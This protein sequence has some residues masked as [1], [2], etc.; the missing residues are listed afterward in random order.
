MM[1]TLQA[2]VLVV[3]IAAVKASPFLPFLQ[4]GLLHWMH[5]SE[6]LLSNLMLDPTVVL[7]SA[8]AADVPVFD[9]SGDVVNSLSAI[10][11]QL[12]EGPKSSVLSFLDKHPEW[13]QSTADFTSDLVQAKVQTPLA[14]KGNEIVQGFNNYL[15]ENPKWKL[16]TSDFVAD[17][18]ENSVIPSAQHRLAVL[19]TSP[20]AQNT[21]S[22]LDQLQQL[23]VSKP[24]SA[25]NIAGGNNVANRVGDNNELVSSLGRSTKESFD[26]FLEKYPKLKLSTAEFVSDYVD[27]TAIPKVKDTLDFLDRSPLAQN[28]RNFAARP[29]SEVAKDIFDNAQRIAKPVTDLVGLIGYRAVSK[30]AEP[31]ASTADIALSLVT[32]SV[33]EA[34]QFLSTASDADAGL[35]ALDNLPKQL[36]PTDAL[37]DLP[38]IIK[39]E[40]FTDLPQKAGAVL[41]SS[42]TAIGRAV[43]T[44]G[45]ELSAS[46]EILLSNTA[47]FAGKFGDAVSTI[48]SDAINTLPKK[49][50]ELISQGVERVQTR[51]KPEGA[52]LLDSLTAQSSDKISQVQNTIL[53]KL[54]EASQWRLFPDDKHWESGYWEQQVQKLTE[55]SQRVVEISKDRSKRELF[56]SETKS[57][58]SQL[59]ETVSNNWK[60]IQGSNPSFQNLDRLLDASSSIT[61]KATPP[62]LP[63]SPPIPSIKLD[64]SVFNLQNRFKSISSTVSNE[65]QSFSRDAS[66]YVED[67]IKT[68]Q[69]VD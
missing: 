68:N 31:I 34:N 52:G 5:A 20:L 44:L 27:N 4:D 30:L 65:L 49:S 66:H 69:D 48:A 11:S 53:T 67:F 3:C 35:T 61:S 19:K 59:A 18:W 60:R 13:T 22:L 15:E 14:E 50:G 47:S 17:W 58:L 28:T 16:S 1:M 43:S 63:P 12:F 54:E 29:T 51:V 37:S 62:Q 2:L 32:K 42:L 25:L 57:S 9:N 21:Q 8:P 7:D 33:Q 26:A 36:I 46:Q 24:N 6:M 64:E 10:A 45:E 56:V 38:T 23:Q 41:S 39:P 40:V 55:T